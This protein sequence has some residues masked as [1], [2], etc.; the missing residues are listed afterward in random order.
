MSIKR[1]N[2]EFDKIYNE[3]KKD[4]ETKLDLNNVISQIVEYLSEQV[5]DVKDDDVLFER[6]FSNFS[7][8]L[9]SDQYNLNV[10]RYTKMFDEIEQVLKSVI[11]SEVGRIVKK[12]F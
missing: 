3:M 7:D 1:F 9:S 10:D 2:S 5:E 11:Q 12:H 8:I 6:V 4:E